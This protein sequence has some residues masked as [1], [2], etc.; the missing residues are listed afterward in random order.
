MKTYRKPTMEIR[1]FISESVVTASPVDNPNTTL[2]DWQ[3]QNK[4]GKV[5][6]KN[7]SAM[8]VMQYTF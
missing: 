5:V 4:D 1:N 2:G 7:I 3:E 6:Q 8:K